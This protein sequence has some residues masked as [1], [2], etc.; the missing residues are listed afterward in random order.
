VEPNWTTLAKFPK[1]VRREVHEALRQTLYDFERQQFNTVVSG[2]MKILNSLSRLPVDTDDQMAAA[3][4]REGLSILLRL[5]SPIV[6]HITHV[7]WQE[8]AYEDTVSNAPWPVADPAALHRDTLALVVQVN[9]KV[10]AQIDVP[11][12]ADK[13]TI[14]ETALAAS[15]VQ[16]FIDG[17]TVRKMIVVPGRL[18]NIVC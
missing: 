3:V 11:A 8:L 10:R 2:G 15:N 17:K 1:A 16:R 13:A 9:G 14:E 5:L 12:D 18:I 4:R 6:P 7:L